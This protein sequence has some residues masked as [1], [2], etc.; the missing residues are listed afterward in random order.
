MAG[1]QMGPPSLPQKKKKKTSSVGLM[2]DDLAAM[3]DPRIQRVYQ[4]PQGV[5]SNQNKA[6][7]TVQM[8]EE[9][10]PTVHLNVYDRRST[11]VHK[12]ANGRKSFFRRTNAE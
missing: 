1:G 10:H 6:S 9:K 12:K 2:L 4:I 8:L 5:H 7:V 3:A 11:I